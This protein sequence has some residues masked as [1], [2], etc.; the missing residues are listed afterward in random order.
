MLVSLAEPVMLFLTAVVIGF[1]VVGM[2]LPILTLQDV[3]H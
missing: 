2:L 1:V 3:V